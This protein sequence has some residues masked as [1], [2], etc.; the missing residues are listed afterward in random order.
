M[1]QYYEKVS[2]ESIV[3]HLHDRAKFGEKYR[4][5]NPRDRISAEEVCKA[6]HEATKNIEYGRDQFEVVI[7]RDPAMIIVFGPGFCFDE[8]CYD[9]VHGVGTAKMAVQA[10]TEDRIAVDIKDSVRKYVKCEDI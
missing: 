8:S 3:M 1:I 4:D 6:F 9:S 5:I 10:A 7:K 2:P